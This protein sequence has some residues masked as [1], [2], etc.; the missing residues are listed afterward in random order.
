MPGTRREGMFGEAVARLLLEEERLAK[1][2]TE[3]GG[4]AAHVAPAR[5]LVD[6]VAAVAGQ[7]TEALRAYLARAGG[8]VPATAAPAA[9]PAVTAGGVSGVASALLEALYVDVS[10]LSIRYAALHAAAMR[11]FEPPLRQLAPHHLRD[12]AEVAQLLTVRLPQVLSLE[13]AAAGQTCRCP[14]PMCSIGI[15]GC[16]A[17]AT[18]V[19]SDAW[20]ETAPQPLEQP[21][22]LIQAPRPG[23]QLESLGVPGGAYLLSVNGARVPEHDPAGVQA[24]VA[25]CPHGEDIRL[26][27]LV[28]GE[29]RE[30]IVRRADTPPG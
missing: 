4:D 18:A 28:A 15:C 6:R 19:V 20:R 12:W 11:L 29:A 23:C 3:R 2:A 8:D 24:K 17:G 7:H 25:P 10:G 9:S 5:E 21:G 14:C 1:R 13:L 16:V 22:Y 30:L 26:E 27:V